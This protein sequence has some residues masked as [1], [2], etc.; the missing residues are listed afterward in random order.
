MI[1]L[2]P[3]CRRKPTCSPYLPGTADP[4]HLHSQHLTNPVHERQKSLGSIGSARSPTVQAITSPFSNVVEEIDSNGRVVTPTDQHGHPLQ[5]PQ[6]PLN[7]LVGPGPGPVHPGHGQQT[8]LPTVKSVDSVGP[9]VAIQIDSDPDPESAEK[10][11]QARVPSGG[12][13]AATGTTNTTASGSAHTVGQDG[14][15]GSDG[16]GAGWTPSDGV[17]KGS[18]SPGRRPKSPQK[19]LQE[20]E[21]QD[22][23]SCSQEP[24]TASVGMTGMTLPGI[25]PA[26]S[27]ENMMSAGLGYYDQQGGY[28]Q[29]GYGGNPA[30]VPYHEYDQP[31]PT[32]ENPDWSQH[33]G[34]T[35]GYGQAGDPQA[36]YEGNYSPPTAKMSFN[37]PG[38]GNTTDGGSD[39]LCGGASPGIANPMEHNHPALGGGDMLGLGGA[40]SVGG[41]LDDALGKLESAFPDASAEL[42]C[43]LGEG[44]DLGGG[45]DLEQ[46]LRAMGQDLGTG[47]TSLEGPYG[48]G[49]SEGVFGYGGAAGGAVASGNPFGDDSVGHEV[50]PRHSK[51]AFGNPVPQT[52]EQ[53]PGEVS[54][55]IGSEEKPG[56]R[57]SLDRC[58]QGDFDAQNAATARPPQ[59]ISSKEESWSGNYHDSLSSTSPRIDDGHL[60]NPLHTDLQTERHPHAQSKES[61]KSTDMVVG[62]GSAGSRPTPPGAPMQTEGRLGSKEGT[63]GFTMLPPQEEGGE[64][65]EVGPGDSDKAVLSQNQAEQTQ[66]GASVGVGMIS[67]KKPSKT[68]SSKGSNQGEERESAAEGIA[69]EAEGEEVK[70]PA[71]DLPELG[72]FTMHIDPEDP[73][74]PRQSMVNRF[75]NFGFW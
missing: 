64:E 21:T 46:D 45:L 48:G 6:N 20:S 10:V 11:I 15:Q 74:Q 41:G 61:L 73:D 43:E 4:N 39:G 65:N 33:A 55:T 66:E 14:T 25:V 71:E 19:L 26:D 35:A 23:S 3:F 49:Y 18:S 16:W 38:V 60:V 59:G 7:Q 8:L 67:F 17:S 72:S 62:P 13:L 29:S 27:P 1:M 32:E 70:T 2:F 50:Y 53:N 57:N 31:Y 51:D 28:D 75:C 40:T 12:D 69:P 30:S 37:V 22:S 9:V 52:P 47:R 34:Y 24:I 36:E 63:E 44:A 68:L 54:I 42:A 56:P 5:I 58:A